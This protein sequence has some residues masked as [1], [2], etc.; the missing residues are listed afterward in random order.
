MLGSLNTGR[1]RAEVRLDGK[2]LSTETYGRD[3]WFRDGKS[4]VEIDQNRMYELVYTRSDYGVHTL[5]VV[6]PS[7][8]AEIYSV[9]FG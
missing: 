2:P 6:F 7:P 1:V 9:M 8:S 4:Y 3:I 5:E